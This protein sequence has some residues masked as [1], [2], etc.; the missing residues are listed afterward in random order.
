LGKT[1]FQTHPDLQKQPPK[2][3]PENEDTNGTDFGGQ[4]VDSWKKGARMDQ[5]RSCLSAKVKNE[6]RKG[7]HCPIAIVF[8]MTTRA[9]SQEVRC[10]V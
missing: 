6:K 9:P 3:G 2:N 1:I 7:T 10:N 8:Q 4:V 5:V